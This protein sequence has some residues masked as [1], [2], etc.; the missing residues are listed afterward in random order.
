MKTTAVQLKEDQEHL[1][2]K[3][4]VVPIVATSPAL[5]LFEPI[6]TAFIIYGV[7]KQAIAI[8][9]SHNIHHIA[10]LDGHEDRCHET[11]LREFRLRQ[12]EVNFTH[13]DMRILYSDMNGQIHMPRIMKAYVDEVSDIAVCTIAIEPS[14]PSDL[15]F[16]KQFVINSAP[17]KKG[18]AIMAFGYKGMCVGSHIIEGRTALV[19]FSE[20][21]VR[22]PGAVIDVFQVQGPRSRPM[23][24]FQCSMPFDSGMSGGPVVELVDGEAVAIGVI[25][26]DLS[27][28]S[29]IKG[30]ARVR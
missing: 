17:P 1:Q 28:A 7:D 27:L 8:T 29:H 12:E 24:C 15:K 9:A 30:R 13:T 10:R 14:L 3:R 26:R 6:G 22:R 23:P 19:N 5:D 21:L 11:T 20:T 4:V 16:D 18:A 2:L 25:S